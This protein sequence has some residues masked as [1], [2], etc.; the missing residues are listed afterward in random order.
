[1]WGAG[2]P[3]PR[4]VDR[5]HVLGQRIVGERHLKLRLAREAREF[6]AILFGTTERLPPHIEAVYRLEVNDYDGSRR[7]QLAVQHWSAAEPG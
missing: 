5:F 3:E 2:F 4:F 7:A 6:E 1:V